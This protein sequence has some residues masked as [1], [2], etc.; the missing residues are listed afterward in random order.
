MGQIK[1]G[2]ESRCGNAA[3]WLPAYQ[4]LAASGGGAA[5]AELGLSKAGKQLLCLLHM[6]CWGSCCWLPSAVW[7]ALGAATWQGFRGQSP[8]SL[9]C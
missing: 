3:T 1:L 6:T 5:Q 8:Q 7:A 4:L 9:I 2:S